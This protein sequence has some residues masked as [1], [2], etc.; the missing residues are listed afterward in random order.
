MDY[1]AARGSEQ[2]KTIALE[3]T[4]TTFSTI[5]FADDAIQTGE[6][7]L[8]VL[9]TEHI[10]FPLANSSNKA[11]TEL[12][13]RYLSSMF[14][15]APSRLAYVNFMKWLIRGKFESIST[16][17]YERARTLAIIQTNNI[18]IDAGLY[19]YAVY[20]LHACHQQIRL[21]APYDTVVKSNFVQKMKR[22]DLYETYTKLATKTQ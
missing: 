17:Q 18:F 9:A 13:L 5:F 4:R 19:E 15:L 2:D 6:D 10:Y 7:C 22:N 11:I 12:D 20:W 16:A 3:L 14:R 8:A 1:L 21:N